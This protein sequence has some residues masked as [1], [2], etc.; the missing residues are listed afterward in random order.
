MKEKNKPDMPEY[1]KM[2]FLSDSNDEYRMEMLR[3]LA[4]DPKYVCGACG[5]A[6][7]GKEVLCSPETLKNEAGLEMADS[8]R[9]YLGDPGL[10]DYEKMCFLSDSN[11]DRRMDILKS[12][13]QNSTHVCSACGRTASSEKAVC[14]PE[15]L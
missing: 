11:E 15:L 9:V 14:S 6:A 7:K 10:P 12:M 8:E 13:A 2:C 1:E 5:R 3:L 4:K